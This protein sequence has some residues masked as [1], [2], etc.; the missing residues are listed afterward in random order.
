[1]YFTSTAHCPNSKPDRA[2]WLRSCWAACDGLLAGRGPGDGSAPARATPCKCLSPK[3][4]ICPYQPSVA[5]SGWGKERSGAAWSTRLGDGSKRRTACKLCS[6]ADSHDLVALFRS[7]L[8]CRG[9]AFRGR[10]TVLADAIRWI[11]PALQRAWGHAKSSA[12]RLKASSR[13]CRLID[14]GYD[15]SAI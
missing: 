3:R 12:S 2:P 15:V 13:R 5:R 9:W 10:T 8:V 7:Q 6:V 11:F 14:E 4:Y 1:M